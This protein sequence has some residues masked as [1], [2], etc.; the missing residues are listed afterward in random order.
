MLSD[1]AVAKRT[2]RNICGRM[3]GCIEGGSFCGKRILTYFHG[4]KRKYSVYL[5]DFGHKNSGVNGN[6]NLEGRKMDIANP[7]S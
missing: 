6:T 4:G 7:R 5:T 2:M 1:K 3:A